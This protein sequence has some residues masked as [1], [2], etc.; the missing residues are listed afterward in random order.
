MNWPPPEPGPPQLCGQP[1]HLLSLLHLRRPKHLQLL[2]LL[3]GRQR[4]GR[5]RGRR[6][7]GR[8][9]GAGP[10]A[11]RWLQESV[12]TTSTNWMSDL[13]SQY[14]SIKGIR[15]NDFLSI[16]VDYRKS[17]EN[18]AAFSGRN[19]PA[20]MHTSS[21]LSQNTKSTSL[22][23]GGFDSS[24]SASES[25]SASMSLISAAGRRRREVEIWQFPD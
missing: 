11:A 7:R 1:A 3:R 21:S 15:L 24:T 13:R 22:V 12:K 5:R 6:P 18:G 8:R 25:A 9:R 10:G 17:G 4:Q 16:L 23:H 19:H 20:A 2:W 14:C